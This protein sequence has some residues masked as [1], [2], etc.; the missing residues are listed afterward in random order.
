MS[1]KK[2][3][4]SAIKAQVVRAVQGA[5]PPTVLKY[6]AAA[7]G[8]DHMHIP[9]TRDNGRVDEQGLP[10]PP[11]YLWDGLGANLNEYLTVGKEHADNMRAALARHGFEMPDKIL[12]FGCGAGRMIRWLKPEAERGT[13][14]G[15]DITAEYIHWLQR[16]LRPP[17]RFFTS[18]TM[19]TLPFPDGHFG[20][21]YAGSV[22]THIADLAEAWVLE[23]RRIVKTGGLAYL[24]VHDPAAANLMMTFDE[25]EQKPAAPERLEE[26]GGLP[27]DLGMLALDRWPERPSTNVFYS[28]DWW[29]ESLAPMFRVLEITEGAYG[30]QTAFLAQAV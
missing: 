4:R 11:E 28:R 24:T 22:F 7:Q 14:W 12:D 26:Y 6:V 3:A 18:T 9:S 25:Y 17:F 29:Q 1:V 19:P 27:D 5:P 8:Q 10:V 20:L 13:V 21:V 23:V 16:N 15:C 2:S 30:Y